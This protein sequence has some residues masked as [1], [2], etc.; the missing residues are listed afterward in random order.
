MSKKPLAKKHL[1]EELPEFDLSDF[2]QNDMPEEE[3]MFNMMSGLV[4]LQQ[5][6]HNIAIELTKLVTA[7]KAGASM[8]ESEIFSIFKR[9]IQTV[10]EVTP[11][12]ALFEKMQEI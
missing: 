11:L 9:A 8:T 3:E 7:N 6:Q 10:N 1:P 2:F 4:Q 5:H 12:N